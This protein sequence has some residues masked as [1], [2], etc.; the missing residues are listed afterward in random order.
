MRKLLLFISALIASVTMLLSES[1][2]PVYDIG[3]V[4]RESKSML[5]VGETTS[6]AMAMDLGAAVEATALTLAKPMLATAGATMHKSRLYS[7]KM[8]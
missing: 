4:V 1:L 3:G 2:T 7:R 5:S 8:V 6:P